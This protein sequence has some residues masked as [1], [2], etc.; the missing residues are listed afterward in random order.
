MAVDLRPYVSQGGLVVRTNER[1][2]GEGVYWE[3]S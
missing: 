1:P 3:T 2:V